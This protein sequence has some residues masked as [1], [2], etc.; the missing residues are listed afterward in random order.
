MDKLLVIVFSYAWFG[1]E[2]YNV[3]APQGIEDSGSHLM[4]RVVED[5][6]G[7]R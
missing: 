6:V 5:S 3:V 7:P 1:V 4:F 2:A